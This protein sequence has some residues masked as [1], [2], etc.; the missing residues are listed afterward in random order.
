MLDRGR[1]PRLV[2][3]ATVM[4][5]VIVVTIVVVM[6]VVVVVAVVIVMAVVVVMAEVWAVAT[7]IISGN[8]TTDSSRDGKH[9]NGRK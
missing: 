1:G 5:V 6:A 4:A 7:E 9:R 3:L 2:L 8:R